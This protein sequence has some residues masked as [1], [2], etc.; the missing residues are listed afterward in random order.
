MVFCMSPS[1]ME[2]LRH[3]LYPFLR[4]NLVKANVLGRCNSN[5]QPLSVDEKVIIGLMV[6]RG[7]S[8]SGIIWGL[9]VG[10]TCAETA[11]FDFFK[12]IV[13]SNIGPIEFPFTTNELKVLTDGFLSQRANLPYFIGHVSGLD[14]LA[15]CIRMPVVNK[16]DN[17]LAYMNRYGFPSFNVQGLACRWKCEMLHAI[18]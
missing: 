1:A 4:P 11:A 3:E 16:C 17:P 13:E 5:C 8:I 15:A 14:G 10:H 12:A 6:A 9:G 7:C 18:S 2:Q